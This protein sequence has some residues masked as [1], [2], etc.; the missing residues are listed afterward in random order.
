MI[1]HRKELITRVAK[2][3]GYSKV[4][5]GETSTRLSAAILSSMAQGKGAHI[6][7]DTVIF[8]HLFNHYSLR[9]TAYCMYVHLQMCLK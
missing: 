6:A 5:V 1:F 3:E 4:I 9:G 8:I 2:T 7:Y